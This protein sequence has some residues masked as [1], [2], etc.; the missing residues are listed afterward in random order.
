MITFLLSSIINR[1]ATEA[2]T[3]TSNGGPLPSPTASDTSSTG[4][5]SANPSLASEQSLEIEEEE[6][7]EGWASGEFSESDDELLDDRREVASPQV[8]F[9]L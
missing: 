8:S 9:Q 3:V 2:T 1:P 7:E 6:N 4:Y 5:G